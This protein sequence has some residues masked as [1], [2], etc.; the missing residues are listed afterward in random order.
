MRQT[1]FFH[2]IGS[3][4][5]F[6]ATILLIVTC[7]SAP[8]VHNLS[9]LKITY[10]AND[11]S[12]FSPDIT[13][14]TFGY[15]VIREGA[16]DD[17][18][19]VA[20]GYDAADVVRSANSA[21]DVSDSAAT[22]ANALTKV[23]VLHPVACGMSFIAFLMALGA[24]IVGSFLASLVALATFLVTLVVLITDF[25]GFSVLKSAVNNAAADNNVNV[26]AEFGAAAWTTLVSAVCNLIATVVVFFTC[27]S[28]RL[29]SR[30]SPTYKDRY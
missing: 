4:L 17:C 28:A 19:K 30:R 12:T 29:H 16:D 11:R 13:F 14:G 22:T 5:L 10:N 2:H 8:V 1:G 24:G 27:C 7:I 21:F 25:V 3:F 23:M 18:S 9:I 6:A 15:C 20:V 26:T